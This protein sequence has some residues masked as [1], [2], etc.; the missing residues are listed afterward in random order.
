MHIEYRISNDITISDEIDSEE[1]LG[2]IDYAK[3]LKDQVCPAQPVAYQAEA[4]QPGGKA[5][6]TA[7]QL[8]IMSDRG[9]T[10]WEGMTRK[11]AIE[12]VSALMSG[13]EPPQKPIPTQVKAYG[14]DGPATEKQIATM[15]RFGIPFTEGISCQEASALIAES[16]NNRKKER[17][18]QETK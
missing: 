12:V 9:F 8:Q 18:E 3:W 17:Y 15:K 4:T 16:T 11:Q 2:F 14:G 7:S 6:P 13:K 5:A 1:A 10:P